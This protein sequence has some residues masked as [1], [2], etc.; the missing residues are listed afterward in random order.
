MG[1]TVTLSARPTCDHPGCDGTPKLQMTGI[2]VHGKEF[3]A[4]ACEDCVQEMREEAKKLADSREDL[5]FVDEV[6]V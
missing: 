5:E 4:Y 3:H 1:K 2:M 6:S